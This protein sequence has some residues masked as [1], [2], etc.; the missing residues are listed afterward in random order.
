MQTDISLDSRFA[1]RTED[2]AAKVIDGEAIIINLTTGLY[3]SLENV[4]AAV[5]QMV[6]D[7]RSVKEMAGA[8]SE[9]YDV[10]RDRAQSDLA[11]FVDQLL[12]ESLIEEA[13]DSAADAAPQNSAP[14]RKLPYS[15]PILSVYRDMEDLLALDPPAPAFGQLKP[16]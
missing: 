6:A 12:T 16:K 3:Y 8:I 2:I 1:P 5:W 4:G 7:R 15:Q 10:T 13:V 11:T 9:R 14:D